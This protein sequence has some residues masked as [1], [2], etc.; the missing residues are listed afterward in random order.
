MYLIPHQGHALCKDCF[1]T[2]FETEVHQTIISNKLFEKGE[3][4]AIG[5][6]GGKG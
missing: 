1:Y 6:S 2:T 5:A 3:V 4:V